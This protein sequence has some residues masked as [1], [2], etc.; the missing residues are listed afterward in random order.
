L[1]PAS[2]VHF[3]R[4]AWR[5]TLLCASLI[6]LPPALAI[7]QVSDNPLR[8]AQYLADARDGRADEA[9]LAAARDHVDGGDKTGASL[10]YLLSNGVTIADDVPVLNALIEG[11]EYDDAPID[12]GLINDLLD[13]GARGDINR[14]TFS[15]EEPH[16]LFDLMEALY[17]KGSQDKTFDD[18]L[19]V[20]VVRK[21]VRAGAQI[22]PECCNRSTLAQILLSS[23]GHPELRLPLLEVFGEIGVESPELCTVIG[24]E[25][26]DTVMALI[27]YREL[28]VYS[29]DYECA[30]MIGREYRG[31]PA[32]RVA[33]LKLMVEYQPGRHFR[34]L[35][36]EI[37]RVAAGGGDIATL[38]ALVTQQI[39][40]DIIFAMTELENS[41]A[42][43]PQNVALAERLNRL[44]S[45]G[46]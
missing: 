1:P 3:V 6:A 40:E 5:A 43:Y 38:D 19:A 21:L 32:E 26:T 29:S 10:R 14:G 25:D 37:R 17:S 23:T 44:W 46:Q 30:A 24:K 9:I 33:I 39:N 7:A 22:E 41:L 15:F 4:R 28:F 34:A 8:A 31:T 13:A 12:L 20:K 45:L 11:H 16:L 42:Q 36:H 18:A 2:L 27:R 35:A